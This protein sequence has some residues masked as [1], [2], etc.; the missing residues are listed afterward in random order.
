MNLRVSKLA[1]WIVMAILVS[2]CGSSP[3][4]GEFLAVHPDNPHYFMFRGKPA[5]LIGS[6]EH[7]GAVMNRDFDYVRYFDELAVC[8]LNIT[9]TFSGIYVE[10]K[11]A[12]GIR[13]NTLA[14]D[15]GKFICPWAR[16][17]EPGYAV[18]GN[19]FDLDRWDP[20]YFNRLKRLS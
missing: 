1:G 18:G 8:G 6:T 12:F 19:R 14:P 17:T 3:G 10:P 13:G 7:Y 2:S 20:E 11:G 16:S 15:S 9:R 5:L 4:K